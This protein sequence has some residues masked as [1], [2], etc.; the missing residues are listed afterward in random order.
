MYTLFASLNFNKNAEE[1]NFYLISRNS[2]D[3]R[4]YEQT[5]ETVT[6]GTKKRCIEYLENLG[7]NEEVLKIA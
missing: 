4:D 3:Y 1:A 6:H 5:K 2:P 7:L